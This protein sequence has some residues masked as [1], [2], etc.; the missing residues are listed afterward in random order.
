[1][2]SYS[3]PRMEATIDNWPSGGK[4]VSAIF[5]IEQ[6]SRGERGCRCTL[7]AG[8]KSTAKKLTY[9]SKARIVDGDD[10]RTYVLELS[11][12][13]GHINVMRGDMKY[14]QEV[15]YE[16]NPRYPEL[17]RLFGPP[18]CKECGKNPSDPPSKLCPGC[19]A[20]REHTK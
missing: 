10:G 7:T 15:I 19:E 9:A 1:M 6:T 5:W 2:T 18:I 12:M 20:Y 4:R 14:Y 8:R 3:N 16:L 11:A 17:L 13:Y